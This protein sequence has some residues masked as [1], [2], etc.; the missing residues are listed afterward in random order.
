MI[1]RGAHG[2][3]GVA[4]WSALV[5]PALALAFA[6]GCGGEADPD[7]GTGLRDRLSDLREE[8]QDSTAESPTRER[9]SAPTPAAATG[10]DSAPPLDSEPEVHQ[11]TE[12]PRR[13]V[14]SD[15]DRHP[16]RQPAI[17]WGLDAS[18]WVE[19]A[20]EVEVDQSLGGRLREIYEGSSRTEDM[21]LKSFLVAFVEEY[22]SSCGQQESSRLR[23]LKRN[24]G[25]LKAHGRLATPYLRYGDQLATADKGATLHA[26][27]T[28]NGEGLFSRS[29]PERSLAEGLLDRL[30]CSAPEIDHLVTNLGQLA[31]GREPTSPPPARVA[32]ATPEKRTR[33]ALGA[34]YL[35]PRLYVDDPESWS[36]NGIEEF[37]FER[38]QNAGRVALSAFE[39]ELAA[40]GIPEGR[41]T[42][43]ILE[44][45]IVPHRT[46]LKYVWIGL[47]L[48]DEDTAITW[49]QKN[50]REYTWEGETEES[51][52]SA[53]SQFRASHAV[54]SRANL[55]HR[56]L[57]RAFVNYRQHYRSEVWMR[58]F[59]SIS[60]VDGC[61][62]MVDGVFVRMSGK[63]LHLR[64]FL[65]S[66]PS[67]Y[68]EFPFGKLTRF[69][70][71]PP[72]LRTSQTPPGTPDS[73]FEETP[74]AYFSILD[75]AVFPNVNLGFDPFDDYERLRALY[76]D[77]VTPNGGK[78]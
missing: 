3:A 42:R 45:E 66:R 13:Q 78:S 53:Y 75:D 26:L 72:G 73:A 25:T 23:E 51:M 62:T 36:A 63:D 8:V 19:L 65:A 46:D 71:L 74:F 27:L 18:F 54:R 20:R 76:L 64:R 41:A 52:R 10:R 34:R 56:V 15:G 2:R 14:P 48:P 60:A 47:G 16:T 38:S 57:E 28:N 59:G 49:L 50:G 1:S 6:L 21:F 77:K 29:F 58:R 31:R 22:D 40:L 33:H 39:A 44:G 55:R 68:V 35:R 43:A 37:G 5:T 12:K 7:Q 69:G 11:A 61:R 9:L 30:A 67:R 32:K 24:G 17:G 70:D 4:R